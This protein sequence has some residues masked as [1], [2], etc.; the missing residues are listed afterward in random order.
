M[1]A[2]AAAAVGLSLFFGLVLYLCVRS[3]G[4]SSDV[5]RDAGLDLTAKSPLGRW[6]C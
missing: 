2:L 4:E 5:A 1:L 6:R 3:R